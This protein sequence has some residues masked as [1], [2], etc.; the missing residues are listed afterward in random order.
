MRK[1]LYKN[2]APIFLNRHSPHS[3]RESPIPEED[4]KTILEAARWSPSCYNEQ[5]WFYLY[6]SKEKGRQAIL[7]TLL[8]FNQS[9]AK[10]APILMIVFARKTFHRNQKENRWCHFDAGSSWMSLA[11][12]AKEMGYATRAMGG[13]DPDLALNIVNLSA[14]DY[15]P[16]A[17]IALGK[18]GTPEDLPSDIREKE[19]IS[20]RNSLEDMV[21]TLDS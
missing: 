9:W 5:P 7:S 13:F 11:L 21:K 6:A 19:A 2:L 10:K 14:K 18:E 3:F 17:V 15:D 20:S 12:Q 8:P 4:L 16:M 1:S